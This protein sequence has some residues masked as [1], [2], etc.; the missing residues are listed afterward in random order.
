MHITII[1]KKLVK[2]KGKKKRKKENT[3]AQIGTNVSARGF[4]AG[5]LA[6]NQVCIR[7]FLRPANSIK[8]FRGFLW[9]Q[10]KC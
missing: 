6:R 9:S 5:L 2:N 8:V 10:S 7:K 3:T 1:I 4:N